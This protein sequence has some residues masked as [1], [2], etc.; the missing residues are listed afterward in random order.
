MAENW[1]D[2]QGMFRPL[3]EMNGARI[4]L[5]KSVICEH[6]LRDPKSDLPLAGLRI[7]DIGCGGGLL[8]EPMTLLGAKVTGVDAL[9]KNLKTAKTHAQQVGIDIAVFRSNPQ[10]ITA[11]LVH[12]FCSYLGINI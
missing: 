3:H 5:I 12:S 8:C 11:V 1:W 9:E 4:D 7:L 2:P 6:F 10:G